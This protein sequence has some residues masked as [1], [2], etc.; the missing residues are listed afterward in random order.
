MSLL[1][2]SE[3]VP[4]HKWIG[5]VRV[6]PRPNNQ[7]LGKATR[8]FVAS[9]ALAETLEDFAKKCTEALNKQDF[10]VLGIED[11]ELW[12]QR[13]KRSNPDPEVL[14]LV[15]AVNEETPVVLAT[16]HSYQT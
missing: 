14:R 6:K 9:I 10:E 16:F 5:L 12:E 8:A 15:E 2:R 13:A 1:N 11:A 4:K 7:A 3:K